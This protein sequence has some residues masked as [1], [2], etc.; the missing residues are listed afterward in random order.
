MNKVS[1]Y[2]TD[3]QEI[4][5]NRFKSV[6]TLNDRFVLTVTSRVA[7]TPMDGKVFDYILS[8]LTYPKNGV[9]DL[10]IR[11]D[12]DDIIN[13]FGYSN[14]TENRRKILQH[15]KNIVGVEV[16][17]EWEGGQASFDLLESFESQSDIHT[18][19]VTLSESFIDAMD[20]NVAGKRPINISQTMKIQS[21][22]T[23]ELAKIL[24]MRGQGV[25]KDTGLPLSV[26]IISHTYLCQYLNLKNDSAAT[27]SQL[28]KS[29]KQ[30]AQYGYPR[31][32]YSAKAQR[33]KQVSEIT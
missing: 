33:W 1:I 28:R 16:L 21:G 3:Q 25:E 13:Q 31:Y 14:R 19:T 4:A 29:M 6:T 17:L 26:K 18:C 15:I 30:L 32:K 2:L 8:K 23:L 9:Q 7:I 22:Y 11:I 27:L 10:V 12:L 24:Q 5:P 20:K